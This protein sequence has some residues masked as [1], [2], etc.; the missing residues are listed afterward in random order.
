MVNYYTDATAIA[1]ELRTTDLFSSTTIPSLDSVNEWIGQ[2]SDYI[3]SLVSNPFAALDYEDYISFDGVTN[4]YLKRGMVNSITSVEYN[5]ALIGETPVWVTKTEGEDYVWNPEQGFIKIVTTKWTTLKAGFRNIRVNYN[6]G[7]VEIPGR[8]KLL[9]TKLV[10]AK[11]IST[12]LNENIEG[13]NDGGSISVG[14]IRIVE[15]GAYGVSSYKNLQQDIKDL[16]ANLI[17]GYV[18]HRYG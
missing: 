10:T 15:P 5:T 6:S 9:V 8:I 14:D 4:L 17:E 18:V 3:D 7:Y 2:Y 16:E 1:Y 11:V 13:R 12:L